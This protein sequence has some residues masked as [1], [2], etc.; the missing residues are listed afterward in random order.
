MPSRSV[1]STKRKY[2]FTLRNI[3]TETIDQRYGITLTSN[4]GE[5]DHDP[6]ITTKVDDLDTTDKIPEVVS[7]LDEAKYLRKCTVSMIDF[8]TNKPVSGTHHC[9][10]CRHPMPENTRPIGCPIKYVPHQAIKSYYSELSKDKYT[11]KENITE[12]RAKHIV[13]NKDKR[14]SLLKRGY[15]ITEGAYCSFNCCMAYIQDPSTKNN[16]FYTD[17]EALLLKMYNTIVEHQ[18]DEIIPAHSW[19]K[20]MVYGGDLTIEKFRENFN[21]VEYVDH[22]ILINYPRHVSIGHLFEER[23]KL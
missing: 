16:D 15:Y 18:I 17:S 20:L 11:I 2:I 4:L 7:F 10:W 5:D 23:L 8:N 6:H 14:I 21:N 22:G 13:Q 9:W 19:K 1:K 12:S 3:N